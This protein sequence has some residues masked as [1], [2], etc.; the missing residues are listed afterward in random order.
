MA[1]ST[2]NSTQAPVHPHI[3]LSKYRTRIIWTWWKLAWQKFPCVLGSVLPPIRVC[4]GLSLATKGIGPLCCTVAT[5]V[6]CCLLQII[7]PHN[8]LL[9]IISVL[10]DITLLKTTCQILLLLVGF[11]TLTYRKDYDWSLI[12]LQ[13][14]Y[15]FWWFHA[16][17]LSNFGC[18]VCL[19]YIY[20]N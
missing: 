13:C 9:P 15:N 3:K 8:H 17:I 4:P 2:K 16:I 6:T 10:A 1:T 7:S 18:F 19:L 20:W 11:D 12:R 5:F 14:I